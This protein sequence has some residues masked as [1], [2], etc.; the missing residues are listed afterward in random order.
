MDEVPVFKIPRSDR[1]LI[2]CTWNGQTERVF[3]SGHDTVT[4]PWGETV[5]GAEVARR[6]EDDSLDPALR[7]LLQRIAVEL[8]R[9]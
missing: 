7:D 6:I 4:L 1:V 5:T 8:G 9:V 2:E 3:L